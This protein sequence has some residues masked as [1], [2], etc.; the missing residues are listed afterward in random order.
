MSAPPPKR[1]A[2]AQA[3]AY[4]HFTSRSLNPA[5]L[6]AQ[7][8]VRKSCI[9]RAKIQL[10][11]GFT[12]RGASKKIGGVYVKLMVIERAELREAFQSQSFASASDEKR[13]LQHVLNDF[14]RGRQV[15]FVELAKMFE[16]LLE[17]DRQAQGTRPSAAATTVE[18]EEGEKRNDEES[19][20][21][22]LI[23]SGGCGKTTLMSKYCPLQWALGLLWNEEFDFVIA[24]EFRYDKTRR[25]SG[26]GDLL[27][28]WSSLGIEIPEG[29]QR[30]GV[31][32]PLMRGVHGCQMTVS[33]F[34]NIHIYYYFVF[35]I[36]I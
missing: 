13:R 21:V 27:G 34:L 26:V 12:E 8:K 24:R 10:G 15:T 28:G 36:Q 2:T 1:L 29:R 20:R 17:L 6:R 32:R 33:H 30:R 22:L 9:Q 19:F 18:V 23:A 16:R 14:V 25:I 31:T 7:E 35:A 4:G 5:V 3:L 11:K